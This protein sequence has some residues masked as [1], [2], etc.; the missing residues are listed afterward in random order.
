[1]KDI[2]LQ[3]GTELAPLASRHPRKSFHS[4]QT[5][6]DDWL[7]TK[8]LQ[9]QEKHLSV[10]KVLVGSAGEILAYYT[11]APGQVDCADFPAEFTRRLPRRPLPVAILAWLG[12]SSRYHGQGLG[13][14]ILAYALRHCYEAEKAFPFVAV[15]IDCVD[16]TA[17][18]F[19]QKFD[20]LEIP[21]NPY[22]LYL[23][24]AQLQALLGEAR[25][26]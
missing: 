5:Q 3:P 21:G 12:V 14:R 13:T 2:R 26:K 4:G 22:R 23:S 24:V 20:F 25:S 6:V 19:F 7:Q 16:D 1:M 11:I 9:Q 18:L 8:A 15:V 17:K 10:T